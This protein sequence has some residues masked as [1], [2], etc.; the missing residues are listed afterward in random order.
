V[1][2]GK[3]VPA[4]LLSQCAAQPAFPDPGRAEL[5]A[6]HWIAALKELLVAKGIMTDDEFARY[7][8]ASRKRKRKLSR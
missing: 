2:D 1:Q 5:E 6:Q 3:T 8:D 7:V 4:S